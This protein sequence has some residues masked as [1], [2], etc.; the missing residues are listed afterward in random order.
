M[1]KAIRMTI[2]LNMQLR[3]F[4]KSFRFVFMFLLERE[5]PSDLNVSLKKLISLDT[6]THVMQNKMYIVW[7]F[8]PREYVVGPY[9]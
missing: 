9:W 7:T 2:E 1:N 4:R 5:F 8:S 6:P 3:E